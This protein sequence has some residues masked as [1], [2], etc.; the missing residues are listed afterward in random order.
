MT[1][2]PY[3][4]AS[5][6]LGI[7]VFP[8]IAAQAQ[9]PAKKVGVVEMEK[10]AVPRTFTEPGR[11]VAVAEAAIRPQVSGIITEILYKAGTK[12]EPGTPMFRIDPT[13]YE[14][15]VLSA[16]ANVESARS[17]TSNAKSTYERATRLKGS[18]L[19]EADVESAR[20]ELEQA[21]ASLKAAEAALLE[22]QAELKWT[23]V[24]SP[25]EG[26]AS[27]ARVSLGDLVTANQSE[28]LATV[29]K[30]DPIAI[31]VYAPSSRVL[32]IYDEVAEGRLQV[33]EAIKAKLTLETGRIFKADGELVAPGYNVSTSTGSI[34]TRFRFEN[35]KNVLLPGMFVRAQVDLGVTEAFL[36]SQSAATRDLTG[37]L[38]TWVIS[39]GKAEKRLLTDIGSYQ[40]NWIVTSGLFDGDLIAVDGLKGLKEGAEVET[41]PVEYDENGV[42]RNVSSATTGKDVAE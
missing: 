5:L 19:S 2:T 34:S 30:L 8:S 27:V 12:L 13:T 20:S 29:T 9:V 21:Q 1:F 15:K 10:Q 42:I 17:A 23:T 4:K 28:E 22:A 25:I 32:S 37:Q 24:I 6:V 14:T 41:I 35:P 3:I 39:R 31:D 26:M 36:V 16:E 18:A 11:A 38:S 40:N 7:L 33:N